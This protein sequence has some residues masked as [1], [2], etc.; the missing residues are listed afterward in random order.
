[1]SK[2][3]SLTQNTSSDMH[4]CPYKLCCSARENFHCR[5]TFSSP[6]RSKY[7]WKKNYIYKK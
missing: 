7:E 2:Q 5:N 4:F 6:K 3:R 1:M